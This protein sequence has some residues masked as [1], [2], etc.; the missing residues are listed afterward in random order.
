MAIDI[1]D[2]E[3][4][5]L[6]DVPKLKNFP[7]GRN[8]KRIHLA[9]LYRWALGGT[10]GVRLETLKVGGTTCTSVEAL[11][12]FFDE[13]TRRKQGG[14]PAS[15]STPPSTPQWSARRQREIEAVQRRLDE[16]FKTKGRKGRRGE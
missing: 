10:G 2:E 6:N 1:R 12:R 11:Q 14:I 15:P 4:V 8:G 16:I 7:L 13:L 3:L 9:T 5:R